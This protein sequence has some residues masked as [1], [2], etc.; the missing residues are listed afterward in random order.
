VEHDMNEHQPGISVRV[1][2]DESGGDAILAA[3]LRRAGRRRAP[4]EE[5][6]ARI[7]E[8]THAVWREQLEAGK[9]RRWMVG[10]AAGAAVIVVGLGAMLHAIP[11]PAVQ[12][13]TIDEVSGGARIERAG[14]QHAALAGSPLLVGDVVQTGSTAAVTVRRGDG[15][16]LRLGTESRLTWQ[17]VSKLK[18]DAGMLYV[19]SGHHA[20]A[21]KPLRIATAAGQIEHLGTQYL[22]AVHDGASTVA[23]RDGRVRITPTAGAAADIAAGQA[24]RFSDGAGI[25]QLGAEAGIDWAWV[26]AFDKRIVIESRSLSDVLDELARSDDMHVVYS[27]AAVEQ[28]ARVV[29][30]HGDNLQ[31]APREAIQAVVATTGFTARFDG[32]QVVISLPH[33]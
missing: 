14:S 11:A 23:V 6:A 26:D 12:V 8:R 25:E 10:L 3:L 32:D 5:I 30:L 28:Q 31:L 22:V 9:R 20:L 21:S 29:Q 1:P 4:P 33:P 18:L 24:A 16:K 19:D 13:A 7:Y 15:L 27:D 17:E 2:P